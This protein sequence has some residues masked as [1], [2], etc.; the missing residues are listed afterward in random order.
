[1]DTHGEECGDAPVGG[2]CMHIMRAC[3]DTLGNPNKDDALLLAEFLRKLFFE[4]WVCEASKEIMSSLL[5]SLEEHLEGSLLD[6]E[7]LGS[8]DA[9]KL[10][11]KARP[12]QQRNTYDEDYKLAVTANRKR[13]RLNHTCRGLLQLDNIP[14]T[15]VRKWNRRFTAEYVATGWETFSE[16]DG[17]YHE[18]S[19]GARIG[20][21]AREMFYYAAHHVKSGYSVHLAPQAWWKLN[22]VPS[23][24]F[25]IILAFSMIHRQGLEPEFASSVP[26]HRRI[27]PGHFFLYRSTPFF[28]QKL[29]AFRRTQIVGFE[30]SKFTGVDTPMLTG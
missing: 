4:M 6:D 26:H 28:I 14:D 5:A 21:P 30:A 18:Q 19:D 13:N 2:K 12:F 8:F 11:V 23:C 1:M 20:K 15:T 16:T 25:L 27:G 9:H 29:H 22:F 17:V 10:E 7:N 3:N 24:C